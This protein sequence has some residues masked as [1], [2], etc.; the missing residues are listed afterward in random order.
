MGN[1]GLLTDRCDPYGAES[2]IQ[3][4]GGI[5]PESYNG[6]HHWF[7]A[8][9]AVARFRMVCQGGAYGTRTAP[10]GGTVA[11]YTCDGG[12]R[13][14]V[15]PLCASHRAEIQRRQAALCPAC[16]YPPEARELSSLLE[17]IQYQIG[18]TIDLS[19]RAALL[20]RHDQMAARMT[21]L[22]DIGVIHNCPLKLIEVS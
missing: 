11:A 15:M 17:A 14:Q 10:D 22:R 12:H 6:K 8:E 2:R 21:E 5:Y 18:S 3:L 9:R 4:L 19:R 7:C 20:S 1:T 16:A 13:G